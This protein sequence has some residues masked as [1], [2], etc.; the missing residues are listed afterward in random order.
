MYVAFHGAIVAMGQQNGMWPMFFFGF[1][2][3]FIVTQ[4]YGILKNK[5]AIAGIIIC[6]AALVLITYSGSFGKRSL[7]AP[8]SAGRISIR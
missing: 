1:M 3:M 2:M 8:K 5:I 7:P 4:V 6:Y